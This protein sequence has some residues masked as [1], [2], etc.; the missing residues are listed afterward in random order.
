[1]EQIMATRNIKDYEDL[2]PDAVFCRVHN[3]H[4]INLHRIQK[5]HK[6]RGGFVTM[7]DGSSIEV[8]SRRREEFL[9]RLLK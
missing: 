1:M 6:G 3:S 4:I 7:E 9:Q 5:Y 2:L 8:A